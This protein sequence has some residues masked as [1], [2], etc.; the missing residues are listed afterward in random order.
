MREIAHQRYLLGFFFGVLP[1]AHSPGPRTDFHAQYAKRRGSAQGCARCLFG[2]IKN[3]TL[4]PRNSRKK[5]SFLGPLLETF[6]P[7]TALQWG[8]SHVNDTSDETDVSA[9]A[10]VWLILCASLVC[11]LFSSKLVIV[12]VILKEVCEFIITYNCMF[13]CSLLIPLLISL[14]VI[15]L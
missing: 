1:T 13:L 9:T 5:T 2:V 10:S 7:R 12:A 6:R 15:T 8:C 11:M 3:L 14:F 4:K